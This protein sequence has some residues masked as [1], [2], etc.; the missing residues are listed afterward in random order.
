M[1]HNRIAVLCGHL[2]LQ[3]A[4]GTRSWCGSSTHAV[5]G[6]VPS[7]PQLQEQ[8]CRYQVHQRCL[9]ALWIHPPQTAADPPLVDPP[10]LVRVYACMCVCVYVCVHV[11]VCVCVCIYI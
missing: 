5:M 11:Y 1:I 2:H 3:P 10:P 7:P 4:S 9:Q 6:E 8:W